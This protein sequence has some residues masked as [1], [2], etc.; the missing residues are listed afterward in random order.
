MKEENHASNFLFTFSCKIYIVEWYA[1]DLT[2]RKL[3]LEIHSRISH[4]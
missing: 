1:F 4:N 3:S 2:I